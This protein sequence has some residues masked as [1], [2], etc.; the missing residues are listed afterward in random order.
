MSLWV[1]LVFINDLQILTCPK[2]H[3]YLQII[4]QV[5]L[6]KQM[7]RKTVH[8]KIDCFEMLRERGQGTERTEKSLHCMPLLCILTLDS[9]Y[10][11]TEK[12]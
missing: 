8:K 5:E 10:T 9:G 2:N 4:L 11:V 1:I 12:I 7:L 3:I 6:P